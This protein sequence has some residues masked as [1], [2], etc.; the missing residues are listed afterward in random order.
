MEAIRK[1]QL[2][3]EIKDAETLIEIADTVRAMV[4]KFSH[5]KQVNKRFTD[6]FNELEG[7]HVSLYESGG[8]HK[9]NVSKNRVT[10]ELY[11]YNQ[12]LSWELILDE[13]ERHQLPEIVQRYKDKLESLD[14]DIDTLKEVL[15]FM[16]TKEAKNF[17]LDRMRR[18]LET[19]IKYSG[20]YKTIYACNHWKCNA[21]FDREENGNWC[22]TCDAGYIREKEVKVE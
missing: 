8:F 22:P 11:K 21:E 4:K 2:R 6:A 10:L 7:Y 19:A 15:A 12:K 16:Q 13:I 17:S 18:D 14:A 9:L 20:E 1:P 5:Y 3:K